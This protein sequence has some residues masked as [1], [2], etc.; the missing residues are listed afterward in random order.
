MSNLRVRAVDAAIEFSVENHSAANAGTDGYVDQ[1]RSILACAPSGFG[2]GRG[3]AVIFKC[4]P[5]LENLPKIADWTLAAPSGHKIYVAKFSADGI[6]RTRRSDAD[7]R[8]FYTSLGCSLAEHARDCVDG[9]VIAIWVGRRLHPGEDSAI[10]IDDANRDFRT[11][12]INCTD[13][14]FRCF[15]C[16]SLGAQARRPRDS[17]RDGG[18]T[19]FKNDS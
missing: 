10:V 3:V 2:Q 16:A 12:D 8:E 18:A 14:S 6:D 11:T 9:I 13:H 19:K 17:R 15:K 4:D 7:A 1:A 5:N